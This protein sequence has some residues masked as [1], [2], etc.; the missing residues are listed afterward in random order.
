LAVVLR[1]SYALLCKTIKVRGLNEWMT[2]NRQAI[3]TKLI[4]SYEQNV[5]L[6]YM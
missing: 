5:R 6:H 1:Q 2:G 4:Q 3:S